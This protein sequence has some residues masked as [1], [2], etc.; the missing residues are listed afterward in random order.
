M[1]FDDIKSKIDSKRIE[2][3][4]L[5]K[6]YTVTFRNEFHGIIKAFF[7]DVPEIQAVVWSQYTP[8]FNDGD[9]C[10]FSVYDRYY[11]TKNFD[12][13][14]RDR[15][16]NY[17]DDEE[18]GTIQTYSWSEKP[19]IVSQETFDKIKKFDSIIEENEDLLEELYGDHC[20]VYLTKE[21]V[22]VDEYVHD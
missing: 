12:I 8:Y 16:Y 1:N 14:N 5:R 15:P 7:E 3:D 6:E 11:V 21:T 10:T 22:V 20:A 9:P 4:K 17:E 2:L 18:Y 13:E 19:D